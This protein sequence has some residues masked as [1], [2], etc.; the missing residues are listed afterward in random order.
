MHTREL[1]RRI[2]M[3][4]VAA[5][6]VAAVAAP[7]GSWSLTSPGPA[8]GAGAVRYTVRS[9]DTLSGIAS[10]LRVPADQLASA[11]EITDPNRIFAGR[12]L[13]LPSGASLPATAARPAAA[14][15][16]LAA[17]S[18]YV[19]RPGDNLAG[20]AARLGVTQ[21]ALA[22]ANGIT[23]PS[24]IRAGTRLTVPGGWHCPVAGRPSF[25]NDFGYVKP[26]T[27]IRHDGIDMF[28]A[29]N[30][31]VVA[32]VSGTVTRFPNP[33]GG[34]ALHLRGIDGTRY[35]LAHLERYGAVGRVTGGT[36]IGYVGTSGSARYT[37]PHLHFETYPR[38]GTVQS[39]YP[40]LSS[41]CR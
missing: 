28:A 41:A 31:P 6:F 23:N 22:Q 36:V 7:P 13:V 2:T 35:Y 29:R 25:V 14:P 11:N 24:Q 9:G 27:G 40:K 20:I 26:A 33:L 30:T 17:V 8:G 21:A 10:R 39:P 5:A 15:T 19:I 12:V 32:P 38:D 18:T 4:V 34:F 16:A 3:G 37:A 1:G